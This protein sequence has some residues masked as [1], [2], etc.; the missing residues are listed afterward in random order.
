[1]GVEDLESFQGFVAVVFRMGHRNPVQRPDRNPKKH[2]NWALEYH[3]LIHFLDLL[4]KGN[5]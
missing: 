2:L 5:Q 3:T 4:L 1:M